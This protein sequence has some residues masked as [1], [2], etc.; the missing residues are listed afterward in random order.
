M[1]GMQVAVPL[2]LS[3]LWIY[4][5]K[6]CAGQAVSWAE[7]RP[8]SGLVGDREWVMLTPDGRQAWMGEF[9]RMTLVRATL[10]A[11]GLVLS[12]P[13]LEDLV[14]TEAAATRPANVKMWNDA[15][16]EMDVFEGFD[17]GHRAQAWI[18][19]AIGQPFRLVRLGPE[20]IRRSALLPLHIVAM[21]SLRDLDR[22]LSAQGQGP[23]AVERFRPNLV[24]D[25]GS[26]AFAEEHFARLEWQGPVSQVIHVTEACIRCV[27]PNIDMDDGVAGRE[28]LA[29]V[30]ALSKGRG[31]RAPT[32]GVC[33]RADTKGSLFRG[34]SGMAIPVSSV[35]N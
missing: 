25:H 8:E 13:G 16:K 14:V 9:H 35:G 20:A 33:G 18:H 4:P 5:V 24:I 32:F 11:K 3:G 34:M 30:A 7:V 17:A 21:P 15:R 22:R 12:A 6:S 29:T 27:M 28:P 23:I 1:S 31:L 2:T 10:S 19:A 26:A